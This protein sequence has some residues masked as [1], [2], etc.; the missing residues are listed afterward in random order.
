M[1]YLSIAL[2]RCTELQRMNQSDLAR[3][4]GVSRSFISRL[5]SGEKEEISDPNFIALLKAFSAD[6][7]AQ[8][9]IIA[10]RCMDARVGPGAEL[11]EI[12]VRG[13]PPKGEPDHK[14]PDVEL[15]RETERAI[16]WL[17]A[18]CPVN[19]DL[20]KHLVMYA[21]LLGMGMPP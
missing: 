17:R 16:A 11:V 14:L 6:P 18:Q 21:K 8:A 3:Q 19:P 10:A 15:P 12:S 5:F 13:R 1:S 4:S 9:E 20:E 2:Q 7:Q